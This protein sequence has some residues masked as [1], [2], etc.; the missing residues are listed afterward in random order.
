MDSIVPIV[1][2]VTLLTLLAVVRVVQK[3]RAG[4]PPKTRPG[5]EPGQGDHV[6][7]SSYGSGN[8]SDGG[9]AW[10][11]PRDPQAYGRIFAPRD[12]NK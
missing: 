12:A 2:I 10:R 8:G 7:S 5:S 3:R 11:V 4:K 6:M 9:R 1:V